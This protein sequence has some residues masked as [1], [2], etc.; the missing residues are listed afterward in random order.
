M[1]TMDQILMTDRAE[2]Y[3]TWL[4][5]ENN[6]NAVIDAC[7]MD[8]DTTGEVTANLI[9]EWF[10]DYRIG[11]DDATKFR[12]YLVR[13]IR[14]C[15][16]QYEQKLRNQPGVGVTLDNLVSVYRERQLKSKG[17][18][19]NIR[20][21]GDDSIKHGLTVTTTPSGVETTTQSGNEIHTKTGGHLETD[22]E[23]LH[24][25]TKVDGVR[26]TI[27][28]PK[29]Q[30]VTSEDGGD[31]AWS[32]DT[33]ISAVN[34]M[35]KQYSEFISPDE[36]AEGNQY[37]EKAYQHMPKGGLNWETLSN[38]AQSGHREYH[39]TDHKTT[40]SY[41]YGDGVEGDTTTTKGDASNPD[42][43][44]RQGATATPDTRKLEYNGTLADGSSGERDTISYDGRKTEISFTGRKTE[45]KNEGTDVNTYGNVEDNGSHENTD[46][47]QVKGRNEDPATL[48]QRAV[49]FIERSNAWLWLRDQLEPCFDTNME[50]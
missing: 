37:Y 47:E 25:T 31:N 1:I 32:G 13:S 4:E 17:T 46:R 16:P 26:E 36:T 3:E 33:S 9:K 39:D 28:A 6:A 41:I 21:H 50:D 35:S 48:L 40:T 8:A 27:T 22:V 34:P 42:T 38:Q 19:G 11:W 43:E 29:V 5:D 15:I 7:K 44:T 2:T 30:T 12:R 20:T 18:T 23:G 14:T 24:T 45:V 10:F 49:D